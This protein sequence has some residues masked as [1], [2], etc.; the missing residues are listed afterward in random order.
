[1]DSATFSRMGDSIRH[2]GPDDSGVF[3]GSSVGLGNQRLSIIDIEGGH[4][5]FVSD[6]GEIVVI[7][8]GEIFNHVELAAELCD[9]D[10]MQDAF[11]HRSAVALV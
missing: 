5:P 8:N 3:V 10:K 1:M 9:R 11:G 4:Q 6:D 7:Q 2:R